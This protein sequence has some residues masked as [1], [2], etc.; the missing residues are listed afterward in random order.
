[1]TL[2]TSQASPTQPRQIQP[3]RRRYRPLDLSLLS[4]ASHIRQL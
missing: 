1:M 4:R 3:P 2:P